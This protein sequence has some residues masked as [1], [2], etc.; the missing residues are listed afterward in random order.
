MLK[1]AKS[2]NHGKIEIIEKLNRRGSF[3]VWN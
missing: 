1:V 3:I 2:K